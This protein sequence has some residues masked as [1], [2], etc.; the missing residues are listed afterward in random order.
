MS[1]GGR[2]LD[3]LEANT[4]EVSRQPFGA[5]IEVLCVLGL[6]ADGGEADEVLQLR[7][8]AR[9][10]RPCV[11]GGFVRT[12]GFTEECDAAGVGS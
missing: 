1:S 8:E 9:P 12:I 10:V 5:L 3:A 7:D 6:G 11:G 4:G 2:D